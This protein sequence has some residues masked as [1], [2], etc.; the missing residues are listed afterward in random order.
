MNKIKIIIICLLIPFFV[1]IS[2]IFVKIKTREEFQQKVVLAQETRKVLEHVMFDLLDARE[3]TILGVPAD[4]LWHNR[5]A[6]NSAQQ[7]VLEYIIK[8]G[9]LLRVNNGRI[10]LVADN[11][12]DLR[13]RRQQAAP[14]IVEVQIKA[15][16]NVS[17]ISNL[18]VRVSH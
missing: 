7:G 11:I 8:D 1:L 5:I 15:Q 16:K 10:L 18:K 14:D 12:V 2:V 4:G 6:F 9:R 3:S 17:L 13:I